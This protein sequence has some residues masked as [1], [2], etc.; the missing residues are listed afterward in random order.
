MKIIKLFIILSVCAITI[1]SY[2]L[3][4]V[5]S[6]SNCYN[7]S[8]STATDL[9][10]S[11]Y[12]RAVIDRYETFEKAMSLFRSIYAVYSDIQLKICTSK[13]CQCIKSRF[14]AAAG[15]SYASIFLDPTD[16]HDL[17][18]LLKPLIYIDKK[19]PTPSANSGHLPF[20]AEFCRK[21][22]YS[23]KLGRYVDEIGECRRKLTLE[24]QVLCG[25]RYGTYENPAQTARERQATLKCHLSYQK[26]DDQF[27]RVIAVQALI[28]NERELL[29]ENRGNLLAYIDEL[30]GN[31]SVETTVPPKTN[32]QQGEDETEEPDYGSNAWLKHGFPNLD[33]MNK[34]S[35]HKSSKNKASSSLLVQSYLILPFTTIFYLYF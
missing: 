2:C 23:S 18:H 30:I 32:E 20:L 9:T 28:E 10:D 7:S 21:N 29:E 8:S 34:Y 11:F 5:T 14:P 15:M 1:N 13:V 4:L 33:N 22:E 16:Y 3:E 24:N 19:A 12:K 27:R 31:R 6:Y 35:E 25:V 26:C 17:V